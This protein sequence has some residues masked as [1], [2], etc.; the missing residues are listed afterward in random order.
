MTT[1]TQEKLEQ[2]LDCAVALVEKG[3]RIKYQRNFNDQNFRE[4]FIFVKQVMT[5]DYE[6]FFRK[7]ESYVF[8]SNEEVHSQFFLRDDYYGCSASIAYDSIK[9]LDEKGF[10]LSK[11][12]GVSDELDILVDAY[13]N[14][15]NKEEFEQKNKLKPD[16]VFWGSGYNTF[17]S[18]L[19]L[20]ILNKQ[21][22]VVDRLNGSTFMNPQNIFNQIDRE[23]ATER[24]K[25][26]NYDLANVVV[27]KVSNDLAQKIKKLDDYFD[28]RNQ[29]NSKDGRYLQ[30]FHYKPNVNEEE[31]K[32]LYENGDTKREIVH[33]LNSI[34]VSLHS[35]AKD[36]QIKL[37]KTPFKLPKRNLRLSKDLIRNYALNQLLAQYKE[38]SPIY[39]TALCREMGIDAKVDDDFMQIRDDR[40]REY[41]L[42]SNDRFKNTHENLLICVY[43]I[44]KLYEAA[45]AIISSEETSE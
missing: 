9:S 41:K 44:K 34:I 14:T 27:E 4:N 29:K 33:T 26:I 21:P 43:T 39:K 11:L 18:L 23:N 28:Y 17:R 32:E 3:K 30:N 31:I 12:V 16:V 10:V 25:K 24:K 6:P 22:D 13:N 38:K 2:I 15:S 5:I 7:D 20:K 1:N 36:Y 35:I 45:I 42:Y 19:I 40:D 8:E 37:D